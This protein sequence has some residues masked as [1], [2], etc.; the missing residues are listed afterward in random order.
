MKKT[1]PVDRIGRRMQPEG[2]GP[3]ETLSPA[4]ASRRGGARFPAALFFLA[5]FAVFS[6]AEPL[7]ISLKDAILMGVDRNRDL[8]VE[9]LNPSIKK[10]METVPEARFDTTLEAGVDYS[11][12]TSASGS[13]LQDAVDGTYRPELNSIERE[14]L[15]GRGGVYRLRP[16]GTRLGVDARAGRDDVEGW[17]AEVHSAE[18]G[19]S[20]SRPLLEGAGREPNL[21]LI[22]QARID[23]TLSREE[24]RGFAESLVATIEQ[25]YWDYSLALRRVD[26]V[27]ESAR[28]AEQQLFETRQRIEVG[29]LAETELAAARAE[30]ALRREDSI[31]ARA[32]LDSLRL[33]LLRL[34]NP[35]L[36]DF[37][38][39]R[40][41]I[42]EFPEFPESAVGEVS[43]YV[44]QA[45]EKRPDLRQA[46]L[47]LRRGE[48]DVVQTRNGVLPRLDFFVRLGLGAYDMSLDQ[49]A[50]GALEAEDFNVTAG[51]SF[52]WA[53]GRRA[54][55]A[56][57]RADVLKTDQA[58]AAILNLEQRIEMEVRTAY[59]EAERARDQL[60]ATAATR[61]VQEE[62]LR[63]ETEKFG[64]GRSTS[65][66]VAQAQT[67]LMTARIAEVAAVV[68]ALKARVELYRLAGTLLEK[69]ALA[70]Y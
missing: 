8:R 33:R 3:N 59:I 60:D 53:V 61:E 56:R 12:R 64:V 51:L 22:R 35:P 45:L 9:R 18:I 55:R 69:H 50:R 13:S 43:E 47:A 28:L 58:R 26:I 44:A 63:A 62:K 21:A 46:R 14:T 34:L 19:L 38:R 17:A 70:L 16:D 10:E 48:L 65:L 41:E 24:L 6:R 42:T 67:D 57:Y 29:A 5:A 36:E 66:F 1:Q 23:T 7:R 52:D 39:T 2:L 49:A 15:E 30:V 27:E 68:N 25:T 32:N 37:W 54:D 11:R 4:G 31:N 20:L 40:I